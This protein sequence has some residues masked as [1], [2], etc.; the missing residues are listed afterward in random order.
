MRNYEA[1]IVFNMKGTETPV[2]EL[3]S[4]VAAAMKEEGADITATENAGRRDSP[5]NPTTFPPGSM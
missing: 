1:L 2:E 4:T 3:I 5:T